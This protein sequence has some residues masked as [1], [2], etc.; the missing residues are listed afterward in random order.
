MSEADY[1]SKVMDMQVYADEAGPKWVFRV[2]LA[3]V[4]LGVVSVTYCVVEEYTYDWKH[5]YF[6][7]VLI[8]AWTVFPPLWFWYEYFFLFKTFGKHENPHA[9]DLF[10]HGQQTSRAIWAG[11]LACM[12]AIAAAKY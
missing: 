5:N 6:L 11:V 4:I 12:A 8:F 2:G 10:K 1:G 7:P 3:A 9:F